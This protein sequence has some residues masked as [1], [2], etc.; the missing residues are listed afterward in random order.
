MGNSRFARC[1]QGG[2]VFV[3][4]GTVTI[5]SCTISGNTADFAVR[6]A[7]MLKSS[8]CPNGKMGKLLTRLPRLSLAQLWLTLWSTTVCTCRRDLNFS[9]RPNGKLTFCSLL[10]GRRCLCLG[11]HSDHLIVHHQWESSYLCARALIL[12]SS[13]CPDGKIA[14]ALALILACATAYDASVN[15]RGC[16]LQRT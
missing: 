7:L 15:Y 12:K 10:A 9:H 8:Q 13:Q 6:A 16:V 4:D 2:G 3:A 11:R 14:D 1:L 5:S